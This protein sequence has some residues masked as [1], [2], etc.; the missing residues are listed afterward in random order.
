MQRIVVKIFFLIVFSLMIFPQK[1]ERSPRKVDIIR[2]EA[3]RQMNIGKYGE[4]ID[5]LNKVVSAYPQEVEGYNLR[6]LSYEKRDQ[7]ME[8]VYDFRAAR[9]IAPNNQEVA[10]N[11]ARAT[12]NWYDQLYQKIDGHRREIAIN[13]AKPVNYLEIGKC[14]KNLGQW[15]TAEE[16]YDEYLKREEGS[17]DEIIRYTEILAHNN[18]IE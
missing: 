3:I 17:A 8:A 12:K 16:W 13:P 11:L 18:H 1:A 7:L 5:L 4:A 6:G 15:A 14:H 9:K 10:K 2:D